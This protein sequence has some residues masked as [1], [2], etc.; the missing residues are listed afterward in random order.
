VNPIDWYAAEFDPNL[1]AGVN[2]T[3]GIART[4]V[5]D[6]SAGGY[7]WGHNA[8]SEQYFFETAWAVIMLNRTVFTGGAPVA[9]AVATPN[10]ALAGQVVQFNG[11][12]S[13]HQD[14]SKSIAGWEWDFDNNGTFDATGPQVSMSFVA[15]GS[16]AVRLRVTDNGS[17]P[18]TAETTITVQVTIPP[19]APTAHAGGPYNFCTNKTPWFLDGT[20]SVN[21]DDGQS[22]PGS[23]PDFIKEYAWDLNGD[24]V[25]GDALGPTP[26]V[27]AL[28]TAL[29]LGSH[30]IQLRVTDNTAASFPASGMGDLSDVDSA[31]VVIRS[32]TDPACGCV[33]NLTAYPKNS[34]VQLTWTPFAGTDHYNIYRG[35]I[36]GGPY[37]FIGTAGGGDTVYF[38]RSVTNG[39]LYYYVMRP[40]AL[41][42]TEI[43][44]SNQVSA[45]PR[46]L[47]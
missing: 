27:T 34:L 10:P 13:F 37:L 30:L 15:L 19:T 29:G 26:D 18:V 28:L 41:N 12:G 43:C 11:G 20:K 6:Q 46:A 33:N 4:L 45:R 31:Q 5:G 21:P 25:F 42:G 2:N 3:D 14:A 36:S 24:A 7:W 22:Q 23:P 8:T 17:P 39:T 1:P 38:D 16:Y 32:G 9:V 40:A 44:Q 35:T 47:R